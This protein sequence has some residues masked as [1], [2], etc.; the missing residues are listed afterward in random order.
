MKTATK[1]NKSEIMK[2]AHNLYKSNNH[3]GWS[4]SKSLSVAWDNAKMH[5]KN[6]KVEAKNEAIRA[7][8]KAQAEAKH[9]AEIEAENARFIASGMD[10]HTYTMTNFYNGYGYK[11][12]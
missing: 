4:F 9:K 3:F 5:I 2:E 11:G 7:M 1:Y 6:A 10:L 8:W 12:D